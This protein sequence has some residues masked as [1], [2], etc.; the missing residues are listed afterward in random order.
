[1][2]VL[3]NMSI[4]KCSEFEQEVE[5]FIKKLSV[6]K[7]KEGKDNKHYSLANIE[8]LMEISKDFAD[9]KSRKNALE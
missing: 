5:K 6:F 7:S 9:I 8:D 3:K 4:S 2:E 1:M